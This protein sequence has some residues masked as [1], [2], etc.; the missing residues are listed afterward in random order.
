MI[1][2]RIR[3]QVTLIPLKIGLN[4]AW[5]THTQYKSLEKFFIKTYAFLSNQLKIAS[6]YLNGNTENLMASI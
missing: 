5:A 6:A 1:N 2:T 3:D 4:H